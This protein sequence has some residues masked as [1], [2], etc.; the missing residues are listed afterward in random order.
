MLHTEFNVKEKKHSSG[1]S[2]SGNSPVSPNFGSE[3]DPFGDVNEG[4][5]QIGIKS[6]NILLP[7]KLQNELLRSDSILCEV[8]W[9]VANC[10]LLLEVEEM[11]LPVE[12]N[13]ISYVSSTFRTIIDGASS[14]NNSNNNNEETVTVTLHNYAFSEVKT[15]LEFIYSV[16]EDAVSGK[17][18]F[19]SNMAIVCVSHKNSKPSRTLNQLLFFFF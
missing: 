15:V 4:N 17:K 14:L 3:C 12:K 13:F 9:D 16:N 7:E 18:V 10:D 19:F 6:E 1:A 11:L 8:K 2:S 5:E